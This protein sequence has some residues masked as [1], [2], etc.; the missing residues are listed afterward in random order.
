MIQCHPISQ[1]FASHSS[2]QSHVRSLPY[3]CI[4]NFYSISVVPITFH[5]SLF[6]FF[7]LFLHYFSLSP[8]LFHNH[9]HALTHKLTLSHYLLLC[10]SFTTIL[11]RDVFEAKKKQNN[12]IFYFKAVDYHLTFILDWFN[13]KFFLMENVAFT[14]NL[15]L[16]LHLTIFYRRTKVDIT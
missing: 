6:P 13:L 14:E 5:F 16:L 1:H 10:H 7:Y 4:T 15:D 2:T 12:L 11:S 3:A 9:T 8:I